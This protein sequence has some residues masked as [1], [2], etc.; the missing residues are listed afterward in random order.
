MD[1]RK[2]IK[3]FEMNFTGRLRFRRDS[4]VLSY[5]PVFLGSA[6][7]LVC[8]IESWNGGEKWYKVRVGRTRRRDGGR[9]GGREGEENE[10][11]GERRK[12]GSFRSFGLFRRRRKAVS[13]EEEKL[14]EKGDG[15]KGRRRP[16]QGPATTIYRFLRR[17]G[18]QPRSLSILGDEQPTSEKSMT[19]WLTIFG[20]NL[21]SS[22]SDEG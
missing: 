21:W 7:L 5:D 3:R 22:V 2:R 4:R 17:I 12:T 13:G 15:V 10:Q 9:E 1:R 11:N 20:R 16:E 19:S 18:T 8:S 14:E 6:F